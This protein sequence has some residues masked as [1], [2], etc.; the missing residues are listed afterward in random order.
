MS[1]ESQPVVLKVMN[2][3]MLSSR[4]TEVAQGKGWQPRAARTLDGLT[5]A[6]QGHNP[7]VIA[8]DLNMQPTDPFEAIATIQ[9][10][11]P[12]ARLICFFSH[13]DTELAGKAEEMGCQEIYARSAFVNK[14]AS[15]FE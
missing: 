4:I 15:F 6:L 10:E 13:V 9:R 1:V 5:Q 8:L 7:K 12:E 2:D 14:L 3:L 11:K